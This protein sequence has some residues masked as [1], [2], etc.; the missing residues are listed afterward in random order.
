[1]FRDTLSPPDLPEDYQVILDFGRTV[2]D[3]WILHFTNGVYHY[4]GAI[5]FIEASYIRLNP[6]DFKNHD[7]DIFEI[8]YDSLRNVMNY[9]LKG[10]E[11]VLQ[12]QL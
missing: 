10:K 8:W 4:E 12:L 3:K 9:R 1:M 11:E 5:K 2:R 7:G 6:N